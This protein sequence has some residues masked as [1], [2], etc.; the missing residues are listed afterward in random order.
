M[1]LRHILSLFGWSYVGWLMLPG[2]RQFRMQPR[3]LGFDSNVCEHCAG[4]SENG[5]CHLGGSIYIPCV[6]MLRVN[7][8]QDWGW[9]GDTYEYTGYSNIAAGLYILTLGS[10][11]Y[12]SDTNWSAGWTVRSQ[13]GCYVQS[14]QI[15][16]IQ[17]YN[18]VTEQYEQKF[19]HT[20]NYTGG[21][22]PPG[23]RYYDEGT[24]D[25]DWSDFQ[26]EFIDP[27]C[28]GPRAA[29]W[30]ISGK[31]FCL[32][33]QCEDTDCNDPCTDC[34]GECTYE[35]R[36]LSLSLE[37]YAR[38]CEH[39]IYCVSST[40]DFQG[41]VATYLGGMCCIDVTF[42][43][44][45]AGLPKCFFG[46]VNG[47]GGTLTVKYRHIGCDTWAA[48]HF[49]CIWPLPDTLQITQ[50]SGDCEVYEYG[51]LLTGSERIFT[52]QSG[53]PQTGSLSLSATIPQ[54]SWATSACVGVCV[55]GADCQYAPLFNPLPWKPQRAD[56]NGL[57]LEV[58]LGS[59]PVGPFWSPTQ[60][61]ATS[62]AGD[63]SNVTATIGFSTED[64]YDCGNDQSDCDLSAV[65]AWKLE[66]LDNEN[67]SETLYFTRVPNF[68]KRW[69][70]GMTGWELWADDVTRP[71]AC[72]VQLQNSCS[73]WG[74][75]YGFC[76][77]PGAV[78]ATACNFVE[79]V[80]DAV[81]R[82]H[83]LSCGFLPGTTLT[84]TP[85]T[86]VPDPLPGSE[87]D[88]A[89]WTLDWRS[90]E[91]TLTWNAGTQAWQY[92]PDA[93]HSYVLTREDD[94]DFGEG[95]YSLAVDLTASDEHLT[96]AFST[97]SAIDCCYADPES[98]TLGENED[99]ATLTPGCDS[100]CEAIGWGMLWGGVYYLLSPENNSWWYIGNIVATIYR[101]EDGANIRFMLVINWTDG[102]NNY[103]AYG[104][105]S[106]GSE[107]VAAGQIVVSLTTN[108]PGA[109][110]T[111]I[112]QAGAE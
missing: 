107:C 53:Y 27:S 85:L 65:E 6:L 100:E 51:A 24:F 44:L 11:G 76:F 88:V 70:N 90:A 89:T 36:L 20:I 30:S 93:D 80:V 45:P 14:F 81:Q 95:N 16:A 1:I 102:E 106:A 61:A 7:G 82:Y 37:D 112:V 97:D 58:D 2:V 40:F 33:P 39:G 110:A 73:K 99:A 63:F 75:N 3:C 96:H 104:E 55:G 83:W 56:V 74:N 103:Y 38:C 57:V 67:R 18:Y 32:R 62:Y 77:T 12:T 71:G 41:D 111:A 26:S 59:L 69:R 92:V 54:P 25:L 60:T 9:G 15:S 46:Q 22:I 72:W 86:S 98:F 50:T 49:G 4:D 35:S 48:V 21:A 79:L 34:T 101:L 29:Q 10:S 23:T 105:F 13:C 68:P 94:G 47:E 8:H 28:G 19:M 91:I 87:C 78:S 5:V 52:E 31:P 108:G 43:G 64:Y 84:L 42:A 109:P 66:Y 17:V